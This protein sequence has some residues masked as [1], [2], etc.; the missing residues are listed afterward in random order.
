MSK[1]RISTTV[2]AQLLAQARE[3]HGAGTD[4]SLIEQALRA[5]L[6]RYE[7]AE[8]DAAYLAAYDSGADEMS[9]DW[10]HLGK[11]LDAAAKS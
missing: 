10:G 9:D 7:D 8:I 2:D 3:R 1:V 11:F 6:K 4:A 5:L